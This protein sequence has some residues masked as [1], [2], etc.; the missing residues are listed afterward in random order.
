MLSLVFDYVVDC[1]QIVWKRRWSKV[2]QTFTDQ[3]IT[4][5]FSE[6]GHENY[7]CNSIYRPCSNIWG[8]CARRTCDM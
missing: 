8:W 5:N 1:H 7:I 3:Q 2:L 4:Q 6:L